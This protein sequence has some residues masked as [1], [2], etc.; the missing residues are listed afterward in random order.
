MDILTILYTIS[1]FVVAAGFIPQIVKLLSDD[2][3]AAAMSL[4]A[5][6]IFSVCTIIGFLYACINNGDVFMMLDYGLCSL[7]ETTVLLLAFIRRYQNS[8]HLVHRILISLM[9]Q[10]VVAYAN[11]I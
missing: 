2:S 7:G 6:A 3:E 9:P 5:L 4:T 11:R 8:T 1:G 10:S